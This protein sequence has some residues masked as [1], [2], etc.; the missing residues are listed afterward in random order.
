MIVIS[1]DGMSCENCV[2]HVREAA[3]F[4]PP[5]KPAGS[6]AAYPLSDRLS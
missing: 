2:R 5:H 1:I 4:T 3:E 6:S